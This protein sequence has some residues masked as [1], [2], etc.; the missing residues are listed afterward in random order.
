MSRMLIAGLLPAALLLAAIAPALAAPAWPEQRAGDVVLRDFRFDSGETLGELKLHYVTLGT[1]RRNAAGR[2]VNAVLLLHGTGGTLDAWL[3]PSLADELFAAG[4]PLDATKYFIILPDGIGRGGSSKPSD[5]L[6]TKFPHYRYADMVRATHQLLTAH[7]RVDHL[8]LV[9]GTSMG[10]MQTW[11]WGE[12]YPDFM[13]GLVPV[14][15]QPTAISGRN[16]LFRRIAIEAI[17]NDPDWNGGNYEKNPTRWIYSAPASALMG[18]ST[19]DWQR[20]APSREAGDALYRELT[21]RASKLDAN[22][23]LYATEAVMDYDPSRELEKIK[24]PLLA[25]NSADD[26]INPP[27]LGVVEPAIKRIP[28]ARFVLIPA[29]E[30]TNGHLTYFQGA[31]WRQHLAEFMNALPAVE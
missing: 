2:V 24:A 30:K 16:W 19:L 20:R 29:S 6:R 15:S 25:I 23:Q 8:R 18:E 14:A 5:G 11:M 1:I 28:G 12:M 17:R 31:L 3:R 9:M 27:E 4:G 7:L 21:E 22:N 10:G 13:D 26:A